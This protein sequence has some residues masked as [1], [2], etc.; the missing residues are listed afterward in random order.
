M[1]TRVQVLRVVPPCN[2]MIITI[3][4]SSFQHIYNTNLFQNMSNYAH[5]FDKHD[6]KMVDALEVVVGFFEFSFST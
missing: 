3:I 5:L 4:L 1:T 2:E 6:K